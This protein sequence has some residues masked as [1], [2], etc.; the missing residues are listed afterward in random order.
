[1]KRNTKAILL[2]L[3]LI[4]VAVFA[5]G[6]GEKETPYQI[7]DRE[8]YTVS[9]KFDANGGYFTTNTSVIVD[10]YSPTGVKTNGEGKTDIALI[11]PESES[12]GKN[13]FEATK[14]GYFLAGWYKSC[15]VQ[16]GS[17]GQKTYTYADKW[18]FETDR[19]NLDPNGN[20]SSSEPVMTLYAAWV[21]MFKIEY[22]DLD[23]K[24]C[25]TTEEYNPLT[26]DV[27]K[28]PQWNTETGTLDMFDIPAREGFTFKEMYLDGEQEPVK[29]DLAHIGYVD[30]ATATAINPTMKLYV[31][32][33]EGTWFHIT[34]PDQFIK[35]ARLDGNYKILADL[36]FTGKYW[37]TAFIYNEFTGKIIGNGHTISNVKVEQTD[38]KVT[39]VGLFGK[40][41]SSAQIIDL[42]LSN[43]E[44]TIKAGA[45]SNAWFGLLA[46]E[47]DA[48]AVITNLQIEKGLLKIDSNAKYALSKCVI[49][50]VCG[51]GSADQITADV[52]CEP[53]GNNPEIINVSVAEDGTVTVT[54][55]PV[56]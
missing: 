40:I 54:V 26:D 42:K 18:N 2:C 7:N 5:A 36:D 9:V 52:T 12:R 35:N 15:T 19:L 27:I 34:T 1:M 44:L 3:L 8:N 30:E 47:I 22:Y 50:L 32:W 31:K 14:S 48:D 17:D 39:N 29:E 4:A 38:G 20:Y 10:S 53:C 41:G 11:P 33:K 25:L 23:T 45:A 55:T 46:G 49:R 28:L 37:P 43:A 13:K 21:P 6:C 24:E 16:E 51:K 56:A